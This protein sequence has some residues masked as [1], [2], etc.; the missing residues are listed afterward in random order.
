MGPTWRQRN[1]L[2]VEFP[3]ACDKCPEHRRYKEENRLAQ[4]ESDKHSTV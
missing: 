2:R 1:E 4:H 3:H